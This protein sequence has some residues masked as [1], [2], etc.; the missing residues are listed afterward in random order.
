MSREPRARTGDLVKYDDVTCRVLRRRRVTGFAMLQTSEYEVCLETLDGESVGW[1]AE[2]E[3]EK[4]SD[5]AG[6]T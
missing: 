2:N 6:G 1:V 4:V 3:V 5:E